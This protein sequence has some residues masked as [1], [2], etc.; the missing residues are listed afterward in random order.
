VGLSSLLSVGLC[1]RQLVESPVRQTGRQPVEPRVELPRRQPGEL[2]GGLL[3]QLLEE[4]PPDV[5]FVTYATRSA[6]SAKSSSVGR[7]APMT[8]TR[9]AQSDHRY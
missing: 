7:L 4:R 5:S 8:R 3:T 2:L 9:R 1:G 6:Q